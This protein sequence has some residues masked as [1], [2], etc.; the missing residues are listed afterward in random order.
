MTMYNVTRTHTS[1]HQRSTCIQKATT[2]SHQSRQS[3]TVVHSRAAATIIVVKL[4]KW[5][6]CKQVQKAFKWDMALLCKPLP[7]TPCL[8]PIYMSVGCLAFGSSSNLCHRQS[9]T[10]WY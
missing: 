10:N 4:C 1:R 5:F 8:P 2:A 7:V 6:V 3:T 9:L